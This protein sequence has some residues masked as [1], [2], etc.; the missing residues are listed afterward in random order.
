MSIPVSVDI[1]LVRDP[2]EIVDNL[3]VIECLFIELYL[4]L[5]RISYKCFVLENLVEKKSERR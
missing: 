4:D 3:M 1:C 5:L 2:C